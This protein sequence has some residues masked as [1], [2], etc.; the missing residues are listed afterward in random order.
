MKTYFLDNTTIDAYLVDLLTKRLPH[1]LGRTPLPLILCPIGKS[2]HELLERLK[3][4]A[5]ELAKSRHR[6]RPVCNA[7]IIKAFYPRNARAVSFMAVDD[8]CDTGPVYLSLSDRVKNR[9]VLVLDS[10]V[11]SGASMQLVVE[12]L[13]K[14]GAGAVTAYSLTVKASSQFI[15]NFFS[16]LIEHDDRALFMLQSIPN[17]RIMPTGILRLLDKK[18]MARP[19][20]ICGVSSLDRITWSD[21]YYSVCV[22]PEQRVYVYENTPNENGSGSVI[23]GY[24]SINLPE[25]GDIFIDSLV[26]DQ[27]HKRHRV[28]G[29]LMR[30]AETLARHHH[31]PRMCLWAFH[32]ANNPKRDAVRFYRKCLFKKV[33]GHRLDLLENNNAE[34]Y[35]LMQRSITPHPFLQQSSL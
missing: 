27:D 10:S 26:V 17:N 13:F 34:T 18:D 23:M 22:H 3:P 2:G 9:H 16:L 25:S 31:Y 33:P 20:V 19:P 14:A 12:E 21:L 15:P 4:I 30:W 24:L 5:N 11:H 32:D 8:T 35:L 7:A 6:V 1:A 29:H 28:G